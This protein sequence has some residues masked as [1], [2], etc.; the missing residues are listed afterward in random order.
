MAKRTLDLLTLALLTA[1]LQAAPGASVAPF[2]GK[3]KL[4]PPTAASPTR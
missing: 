3:W 2:L 1:I 4:D